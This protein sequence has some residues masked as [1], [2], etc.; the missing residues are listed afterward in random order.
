MIKNI[1]IALPS[2]EEQW[3]AVD[4]AKAFEKQVKALEQLQ[5]ATR[6]ELN[7]LLP[8]ILAKAFAGDL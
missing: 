1:D 8:S 2:L 5:E 7:A 6:L 4:E 3:R